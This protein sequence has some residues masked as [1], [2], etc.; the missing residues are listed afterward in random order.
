MRTSHIRALTGVR[1]FAALW[2][3]L[4][5]VARHNRDLLQERVPN[6]FEVVAPL[7]SSGLRGVDLFFMLSGFVLALNYLDRLGERFEL[8]ATL[9]FLWL[10]LARIWPLYAIVITGAGVLRLIRHDLWGSAKVG[11][12]TPFQWA[13]QLLMVQTWFP[14]EKGADSWVGPAWSLSAEWFA[15]L[16]FPVIALLVARIHRR[17]AAWQLMALAFVAMVPLLVRV[18]QIHSMIGTVWIP[19]VLCEFVAGMLI[20]CAM[21]RLDPSNRVRR[22]AG[23]GAILT[24]VASVAWLYGVRAVDQSWWAVYV[25]VLFIPLIA[26]LAIG[27]GPLV[28]LLSTRALVLGGGLSYALYLVHSPMLRLFRDVT[29][30][31]RFHLDSWAS[32]LAELLFVPVMVLVAWGCYR[33]IEEPIRRRMRRIWPRRHDLTS[34]PQRVPEHATTGR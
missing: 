15:Y 25:V 6:A 4:Y 3:V 10:R 5:H 28:G 26:L 34:P 13:K 19:R 29:E 21:S 16:L 23:V 12:V 20:C 27:T 32:F 11:T 9:E 2:V 14:N 18:T 17:L 22:A 1:F 33:F 31:T 8:R 24:V 30:F 7:T